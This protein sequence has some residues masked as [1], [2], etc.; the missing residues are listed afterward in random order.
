MRKYT[1]ILG[2]VLAVLLI[3]STTR[4]VTA[5]PP[6]ISAVEFG[7]PGVGS[8][9][10]EDTLNPR[11][12]VVAVGATVHFGITSRVHG[13]AI[14][15]AGT[16]PS[17]VDASILIDGGGNC[18]GSAGNPRYINDTNNRLAFFNPPCSTNS[19]TGTASFT[20]NQPGRFLVI[21]TF[22]SHF[23]QRDMY[24]WVIVKD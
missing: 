18:P 5:H 1:Q 2:F 10:A 23:V 7:H 4:Y 21:C 20:F 11:T 17:D 22:N 6:V 13:V 15:D 8:A 9:E 24:G 16:Q 12:T 19:Q 3:L 14:Y